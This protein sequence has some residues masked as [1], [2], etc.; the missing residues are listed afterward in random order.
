MSAAEFM[1]SRPVIGLMASVMLR[2]FPLWLGVVDAAKAHDVSLI[3][4]LGG[5]IPATGRLQVRYFLPS[6]LQAAIL[7]DL[8]DVERLD[9]LV[10]WAGSGA[11]LGMHVNAEEMNQF[12][13]RY[14]A[15]PIVNYEGVL[16]GI[17]SVVTDTYRD[18]GKLIAHLIEAHDRRRFVLI[19]GPQGHMETE[20]RCRAYRDTLAKYE[21]SCN[22]ALIGPPGAWEPEHGSA[23]IDWLL[24]EHHLKPGVDF[25]AIV[26][27]EVEYAI[28]AVQ[29]LQARGVHVPSDVAVVGFND[30]PEARTLSPSVT[31]MKKPFYTAGYRAV[32]ALLDLIQGRPV[33]DRIEV[34]AELVI[35]RSC[36]CWPSNVAWSRAESTR[37]VK[38]T[39]HRA[40][41][42]TDRASLDETARWE[43]VIAAIAES[44]APLVPLSQARTWAIRLWDV[45]LQ[46]L[47]ASVQ[48][49]W[50]Q[51]AFLPTLEEALRETQVAD[52]VHPEEGLRQWHSVLTRMVCFL[53]AHLA[54]D[55]DSWA[56]AVTLSQQAHI[57]VEKEIQRLEIDR[58][59]KIADRSRILLE[60]SQDMM[61]AK[62]ISQLTDVL[63]RRLPELGIL[64]GYL[65][66]YEDPRP[67]VYPQ[68]APTWSRLVLAFDCHSR[69]QLEPEGRRFRS[70]QLVPQTLLSHD[71]AYAMVAM[72]LYFAQRQF[73]FMLFEVGPRDGPLYRALTQ[74]ISSVLQ[75]IMLIR[76]QRQAE[77][78][79]R[80]REEQM[81]TLIEFLPIGFW[82][83]DADG[84]YIMQNS[85]NRQLVGNNVGLTLEDIEIDEALRAE[86][87]AQ[88]ERVFEGEAIHSESVFHI[89]GQTRV[90]QQ[91]VVPVWVEAEVVA[92]LGIMIDMTEQREM[93]ASL[94]Q[95]VRA[96]DE[97]RRAA[98]AANRAK[99]TFLANMSHE[100]RT[101]LSAVLGF[102]QLMVHD[103][104][105]T[106]QQGENLDIISRSGEHLLA[107]INDMLDLSKIEAGKVTLETE[108]FDLHEILLGLGEMFSL[109][110]EQKRVTVVFDLGPDVPR[111]VRADVGKLRQ[112]LI[113]LL[114]NAVK[115]TEN[116]GIILRVSVVP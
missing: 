35:R 100:L 37:R 13:D 48:D 34:P 29:A 53:M 18:M 89:N 87:Q 28:G 77:L 103:A 47:S 33:P 63:A 30:R 82:A 114:G 52:R 61:N 93:E 73:G 49:G 58:W 109:Y 67:Y 72:P 19:R 101:S 86:W 113:N 1:S 105:L 70:H 21:L 50:A 10:T 64:K 2:H 80:E 85:V 62:D 57:L 79:L 16:A 99:S 3:C 75:S 59:L 22:A 23:M 12:L 11:G 54:D 69:V 95:A 51:A 17:P 83:K 74:E 55:P 108:V 81:R 46:S 31:V 4:F 7:Y 60:I 97:A 92:I 110:A 112:V 65:A 42:A 76:E 26:A 84:R 88:D 20:A 107:L 102:S 36:G 98:E 5:P 14:R 94:R 68:P 8:V 39:S 45:L 25:D 38:P 116:G 24:D 71:R 78:A 104:N 66:L 6:E 44:I 56:G 43:R 9:G 96:A 32:E 115:F 106:P 27:T 90:Y 40:C 111:Y 15:L 41:L 91:I